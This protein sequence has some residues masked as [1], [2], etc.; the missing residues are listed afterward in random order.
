M[1]LL[2]QIQSVVKNIKGILHRFTHA[3]LN[4]GRLP[5]SLISGEVV[6]IISYTKAGSIL[7]TNIFGFSF[8]SREHMPS[9]RDSTRTE[10]I[11]I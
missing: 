7:E 3:I 10:L 9:N 1:K 4:K 11:V 2:V 5:L 6:K 8:T